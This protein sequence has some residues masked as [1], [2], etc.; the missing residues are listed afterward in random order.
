[1]DIRFGSSRIHGI[2]VFARRRFRRGDLI[3]V[4]P[5]L[6]LPDP[7]VEP[8]GPV[9]GLTY[10]WGEGTCALALGY[11]S[12]YNHSDFPKAE[13]VADEEEGTITIIAAEEI[14]AGEEITLRYTPDPGDLWF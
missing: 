2:G 5:V 11:G 4:C 8:G 7:T 6:V 10:E 13:A 12:L 14:L 9:D 3:E 1:M